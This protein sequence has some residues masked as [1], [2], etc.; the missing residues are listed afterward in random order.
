MKDEAR[1]LAEQW[2]V[3]EAEARVAE[4]EA[5]STRLLL[6][7]FHGVIDGLGRID[8]EVFRALRLNTQ[9]DY[10]LEVDRAVRGVWTSF[11]AALTRDAD[12]KPDFVEVARAE[13]PS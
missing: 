8:D 2:N 10:D 13:A 5:R 6:G 12:A 7:R 1:A 4:A 9:D 3:A 11:A